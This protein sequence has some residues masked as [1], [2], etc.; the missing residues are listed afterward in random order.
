[1][2]IYSDKNLYPGVNAH[3]NSF[4][5]S[6]GRHWRSFHANHITDLERAIRAKLP[7]GYIV[8]SEESLQVQAIDTESGSMK[9]AQVQPDVTVFDPSR[10]TSSGTTRMME[11][12]GVGIVEE[13]KLVDLLEEEDTLSSLI[14][15]EIAGDSDLGRPVTRIELLSPSNKPGGS[16]YKEYM[17]KKWMWLYLGLRLVEIDYLHQTP[18]IA[19]RLPSYPH[20]QQDAY[21]YTV[22]VSDPRPELEDGTGFIYKIAVDHLLPTITIPLAGEDVIKVDLGAA[23][24]ITFENSPFLKIAV[25]YAQDPVNFDR[26]TEAD[27]AKISALLNQIRETHQSA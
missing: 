24:Q 26:Y 16:I 20:Q 1:M 22:I 27:C 10:R 7:P 19:P 23:Y 21:P 25:D 18:P 9:N 6:R 4:L 11:V 13:V 14:V 17:G 5:Q 8:A 12:P 15:Y 2:A 3:L